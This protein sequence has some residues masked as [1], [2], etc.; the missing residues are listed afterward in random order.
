MSE[1]AMSAEQKMAERWLH[2][3]AADNADGVPLGGF[4]Q[5]EEGPLDGPPAH[6]SCRCCCVIAPAD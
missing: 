2:L 1:T 4:F 3:V 6:V 5:S